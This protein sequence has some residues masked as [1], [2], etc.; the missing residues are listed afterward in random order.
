VARVAEADRLAVL[1][2]VGDDEDLRMAGEL[3]LVQHV[4]LQPAEAT[5]EG[6]LLRGCDA[7]VAEDQHVVVQV[8]EVDAAEVALVQRLVEVQPDH[9]GGEA[10]LDR[11]D[12][13]AL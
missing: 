5:A 12:L 3:E 7:L 11:A 6:D 9:F 10:A 8:G 2:D 1:D 13:D 4:D